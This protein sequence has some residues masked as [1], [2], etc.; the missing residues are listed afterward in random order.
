MDKEDL[1]ER[2]HSFKLCQA[3]S[4]KIKTKVTAADFVYASEKEENV[5]LVKILPYYWSYTTLSSAATVTIGFW[6]PFKFVLLFII[7]T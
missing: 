5:H 4:H 7:K 2:T 6:T 1:K 3:A